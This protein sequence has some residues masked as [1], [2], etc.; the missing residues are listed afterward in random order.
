MFDM[1]THVHTHIKKETEKFSVAARL[2]RLCQTLGLLFWRK[3]E[4]D[5]FVPQ[6]NVLRLRLLFHPF[7]K[8]EGK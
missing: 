7:L 1:L 5:E 8:V 6:L 2:L 4:K 3:E